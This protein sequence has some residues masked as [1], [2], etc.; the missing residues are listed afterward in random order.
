MAQFRVLYTDR[1]DYSHDFSLEQPLYDAI[2]A[3]IVDARLNH[4][5]IDWDAY[6]GHLSQADAVICFRMPVGRR[7]VEAAPRLKVAVR[8]GVGYE[9]FD[10]EAFAERGIPACNVPDY[11]SEEVAVHALSLILA[12]R[13]QVVFY[14]RALRGGTW[15]GA[16]GEVPMR[17]L[18]HLT[19]GVIGLGRI[20]RAFAARARAL[21][22]ELIACDPFVAPEAF[23]AARADPVGL[24]ELL[25]RSHV[26]SIHV[27]LTRQTRH[28]IGGRELRLMQA[29]A[30]LVNTARGAVVDQLVLAEALNAGVLEGAACDVWEREPTPL[31]HPLL[32][33]KNFI[34]SPHI[35]GISVE[36]TIDNRTK[37]AQEVV[38]VLSGQPPLNQVTPEEG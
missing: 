16:P 26:V 21:F 12:L 4:N 28:M 18:S 20:G 25:S 22:G 7:A 17:R 5:A 2:G 30:V 35:A 38:R 34:A 1:G 37:Q 14:D 33:C 19:A 27:P 29:N 13:R 6:A 9:N 3:E 36:S 32:N 8:S 23:A 15:R 10:L 31:D 24:D 11:G